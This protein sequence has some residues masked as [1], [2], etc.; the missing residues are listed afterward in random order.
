[1][2]IAC[3]AVCVDR[4]MKRCFQYFHLLFLP[5]YDLKERKICDFNEEIVFI[6]RKLAIDYCIWIVGTMFV[7]KLF[8]Y[9]KS[10]LIS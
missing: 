9:R 2:K 5:K 4:S 1:M 10:T 6:A 7:F 8:D 3:Q